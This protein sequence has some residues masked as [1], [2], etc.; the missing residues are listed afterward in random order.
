M[1]GIRWYIRNKF[2]QRSKFDVDVWAGTQSNIKLYI[3]HKDFFRFYRSF[4]HI[5]KLVGIL[6]Y[7]YIIYRL[8]NIRTG[9]RITFLQWKR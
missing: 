5:F 4:F 7:K 8:Q 9:E 3:Y 6:I 2:V 1:H